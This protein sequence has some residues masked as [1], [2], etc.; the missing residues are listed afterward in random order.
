M[1]N[2]LTSAL[3]PIATRARAGR[4][5]ALVLGLVVALLIGLLISSL[6]GAGLARVITT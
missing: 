4:A 2:R 5:V 3:Q 1:S 6:N